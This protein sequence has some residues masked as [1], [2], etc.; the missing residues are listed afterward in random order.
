MCVSR[1]TLHILRRFFALSFVRFTPH[2]IHAPL[3][4]PLEQQANRDLSGHL[5]QRPF[6]RDLLSEIDFATCPRYFFVLFPLSRAP[7]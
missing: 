3:R 2:A 1:L 5:P 4:D 6:P 7:E